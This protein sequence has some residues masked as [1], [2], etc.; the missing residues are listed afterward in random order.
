MENDFVI[1]EHTIN[2]FSFGYV[3]L[4]QPEYYFSFSPAIYC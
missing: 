1:F 4:P 2:Q 3:R